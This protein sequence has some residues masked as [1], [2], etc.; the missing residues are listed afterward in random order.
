MVD[1]AM[2]ADMGNL[3]LESNEQVETVISAD[4]T[5]ITFDRVG[6]G[7]PVVVIGGGL[8]AKLMFAG[9]VEFLSAD[10]T[11]LN[12]DR[13]GRGQSGDGDHDKYT[14]DLEI[15]DLQAVMDAAGETC[16]VFTNCTGG[17][18]AVLA[19]A[20]GVPMRKL[21]MYE[22]PYNSPKVPD[23]Y[24]DRLRALVAADRRTEAVMLFQRES[25]GF[26]DEVI[27]KFRQH[28]IWPI[29]ESVAPTL[30]YDCTLG[31]DHGDIPY[32]LLPKVTVPTFVIDGGASPPWIHEACEALA[33]GVPDGRHHR[34]PDEGHVLNQEVTA[35]LVR[36]FFLS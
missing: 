10:F 13:R 31:I 24:M 16:H 36:E 27:A 14:V 12:Y 9:L 15:Q 20:Q 22:P 6:S 11:V 18:L 25:V 30:I 23:D 5:P 1:S 19:A 29:F 3:R 2:A 26:P 7:P 21:A 8:N 17:M 33:R 32:E 34:V 28:P 35:P 4:G